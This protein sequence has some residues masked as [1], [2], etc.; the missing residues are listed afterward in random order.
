MIRVFLIIMAIA[1]QVN[2]LNSSGFGGTVDFFSNAVN[3][4]EWEVEYTQTT[5]SSSYSDENA[6]TYEDIT[7]DK[8]ANPIIIDNIKF[9]TGNQDQYFNPITTILSKPT[10]AFK[11]E[12]VNLDGQLDPGLV[13]NF[14]D[15]DFDKPILLDTNRY[16]NIDIE[17]NTTLSLTM[18][19]GQYRGDNIL[20]KDIGTGDKV[21]IYPKDEVELKKIY[22]NPL[23]YLSLLSVIVFSVKKWS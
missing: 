15:I 2:E 11:Q 16:F 13:N 3:G 10:G 18:A 8:D 7:R 22:I 23:I 9:A 21:Q 19:Y 14:I 12:I 20:D 4:T 17:P 5:I 1:L 6:M